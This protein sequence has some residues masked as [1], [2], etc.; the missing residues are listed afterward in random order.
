MFS[1]S[2]TSQEDSQ[3]IRSLMGSAQG[4]GTPGSSG[5]PEFRQSRG[6]RPASY[7]PQGGPPTSQQSPYPPAGSYQAPGYQQ[8][9]RGDYQHSAFPQESPYGSTPQSQ[10]TPQQHNTPQHSTQQGYRE[11]SY[12][13]SYSYSQGYDN[14]SQGYNNHQQSNYSGGNQGQWSNTSQPHSSSGT[15]YGSSYSGQGGKGGNYN[16]GTPYRPAAPGSKPPQNRSQAQAPG[17]L[18][19]IRISNRR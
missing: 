3:N 7:P 9:A 11:G 1:S 19:S 6:Q 10:H 16:T 8:P 14:S 18:A 2:F 4:H 15:Q 5:Y 13:P 12:N 17:G